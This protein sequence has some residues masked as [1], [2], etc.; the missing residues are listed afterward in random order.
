MNKQFE[1]SSG[2]DKVES[3]ARG[4]QTPQEQE[5]QAAARRI[6]EAQA[7]RSAKEE[8]ARRKEERRKEKESGRTP[9]FGGWLA[10]VI[11][12]SVA[13]LALGAIVT[14]G[15]FDLDAARSGMESGYRSAVYEFSELVESMDADLAKARVVSGNYE[16]QKLLTD[17]LVESELAEKC[18]EDFP[19]EGHAAENLTAFINRVGS[20]ARTLLYKLAAGGSLDAGEE[21]VIEYMYQTTQQLREALPALVKSADEGTVEEML[22][23]DGDFAAG[24]EGLSAPTAEAPKSIQDGPFSQGANKRSS[25]LL[26]AAPALSEREATDRANGYFRDYGVKSLRMTGKTEGSPACYNFEFTDKA[27]REYYAQITR[28]GGYLLLLDA[29]KEC[30][31][32]NYDAENCVDIATAFLEGCGYTSMRPVWASEAG[33]ECCVS[34][35]YEQDG[36]LCYP[37]MIKVKVCEDAGIVTGVEAHSYLYCHT[38]RAAFEARVPQSRIEANAAARMQLTSVRRAVIAA[39][40]REVFA[41]EVAGEYGGRQ[42]FAYIDANTGETVDIFVVVGTDR[43]EMV[44]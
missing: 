27:G 20:Y 1:S 11:S 43:G 18:I 5:A 3:I 19:V 4:G 14:V 28:Q 7:R 38:E 22:A 24:F 26:E 8:K 10:A 21:E 35:V 31:A 2:A 41:Y 44:M 34:F 32:H 33:T 13:V 36:V 12:L 37:D 16:M 25:A 9:G 17:I 23:A 15:Y 30:E 6:E 42:Y 40:G 39:D 29:Y